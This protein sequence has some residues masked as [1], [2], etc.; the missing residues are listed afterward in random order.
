M[1]D[2]VVRDPD[3]WIDLARDRVAFDDQPVHTRGEKTY[4]VLYKPKGYITTYR[5]PRGRPTVYDL[6]ADAG[7]WLAPVG[8][9]DQ[10]TTG[11]L[12]MTNDTQFAERLTN[13][14][15]KAPKTYLVKAAD[16]LSDEQIER[17]RAGVEL[18]DGPTQPAEVLRVRDA[19]KHTFIQVTIR[20]G[21]NRQVR[22]MLEAIG[23]RV[24]KLVRTRIGTL[25]IG[26]LAIGK[27]RELTREE[28]RGLVN[29]ASRP[30]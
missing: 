5:D 27:W 9:L 12:L 2:R 15:Y 28:V 13:P 17:L 4:I 14:A 11:L 21:R 6:I 25:E 26:D 1:N 3:R 29:S 7:K 22:R 24:L 18:N 20:E 23:S 10:D 19:G 30:G 8:R 16:L